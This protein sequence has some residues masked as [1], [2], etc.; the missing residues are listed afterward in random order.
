ML[1]FCWWQFRVQHQHRYVQNIRIAQKLGQ[2]FKTKKGGLK[3]DKA[4]PKNIWELWRQ[5]LMGCSVFLNVDL[6]VVVKKKFVKETYITLRYKWL[7]SSLIPSPQTQW[8]KT[9]EWSLY[10]HVSIYVSIYVMYLPIFLSIYLSMYRSIYLFIYLYIYVYI[11]VC[12]CVC[13]CVF[14]AWGLQQQSRMPTIAWLFWLDLY[15]AYSSFCSPR[16]RRVAR[17]W[18]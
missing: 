4:R 8:W 6:M 11:S 15:P 14:E 16:L 12:V 13:V 2:V 3:E 10:I 5:M 7:C 18:L 17:L 9:R 1:H